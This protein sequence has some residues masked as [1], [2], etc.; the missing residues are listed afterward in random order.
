MIKDNLVLIFW[1]KSPGDEAVIKES[2]PISRQSVGGG[3]EGQKGNEFGNCVS[4]GIGIWRKLAW[5]NNHVLNVQ[6][7]ENWRNWKQWEEKGLRPQM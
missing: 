4:K 1:G 3:G 5:R 6:T 2:E 7:K